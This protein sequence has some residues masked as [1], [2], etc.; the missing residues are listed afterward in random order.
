MLLVNSF[1][2]GVGRAAASRNLLVSSPCVVS[3]D[4][5]FRHGHWLPRK[6]APK[7][8]FSLRHHWP[9]LH[10]RW[11]RASP[12]GRAH[13]PRQYSFSLDNR[14]NRHRHSLFA[15]MAVCEAF[16]ITAW[17]LNLR[18]VAPAILKEHK[19]FRQLSV[20]LLMGFRW[21]VEE[22]DA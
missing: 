14:P 15:G 3:G 11:H 19:R 22:D 5:P 21:N 18:E 20:S 13:D 4:V 12:F 8:L 7:S 2:D 16:C 9:S 17:R 1:A 10:D 6:L